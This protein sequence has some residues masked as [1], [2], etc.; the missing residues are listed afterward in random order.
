MEYTMRFI[1]MSKIYDHQSKD[2]FFY[3]ECISLYNFYEF[4]LFNPHLMN[5]SS[6]AVLNQ[7]FFVFILIMEVR[8]KLYQDKRLLFY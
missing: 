3:K 1:G 6:K 8:G 5:N 7:S 4:F 2:A